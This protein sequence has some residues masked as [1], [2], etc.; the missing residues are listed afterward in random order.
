MISVDKVDSK[1]FYFSLSSIVDY[2]CRD[3]RIEKALE[4]PAFTQRRDAE[5]YQQKTS[6]FYDTIDILAIVVTTILLMTADYKDISKNHFTWTLSYLSCIK[7]ECGRT[8]PN[9]RGIINHIK[10]LDPNIDS[11]IATG[12]T[13]TEDMPENQIKVTTANSQATNQ[14]SSTNPPSPTDQQPEQ[15]QQPEPNPEAET[16]EGPTAELNIQSKSFEAN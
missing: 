6:T 8:P 15:N 4:S 7:D 11:L 5:A 10:M 3:R 12:S 9:V 14:P 13:D 1:R 2:E 16:E